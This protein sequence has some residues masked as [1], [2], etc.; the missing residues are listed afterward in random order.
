MGARRSSPII[1]VIAPDAVDMVA[2]VLVS[3]NS[4]RNSSLH[5]I[6]M[7]LAGFDGTGPGKGASLQAAVLLDALGGDFRREIVGIFGDQ[8]SM[9]SFC[10]AVILA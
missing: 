6:V 3:S 1:L 2:V 8:L 10:G 4:I 9:A 5:A 7:L